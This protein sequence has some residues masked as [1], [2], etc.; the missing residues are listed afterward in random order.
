[1]SIE[2][3]PV[4]L[5]AIKSKFSNGHIDNAVIVR[6]RRSRLLGGGYFF[7][8]VFFDKNSPI[9]LTLQRGGVREFAKICSAVNVIEDVGLSKF[10]VILS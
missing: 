2:V 8:I 5:P 4:K 6:K 1:M 7:I 10:E 9:K 3:W